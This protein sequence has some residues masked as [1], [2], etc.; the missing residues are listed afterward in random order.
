MY[1][2]GFQSFLDMGGYGLYVWLSFGVS[3]LSLAWL[4]LDSFFSKKALFKNVHAEQARL[5][6]IKVASEN[7]ENNGVQV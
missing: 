1:F 2:D 6:R 3:F 4:W 5:A 7:S